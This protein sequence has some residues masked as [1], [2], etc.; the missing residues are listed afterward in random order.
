VH[1]HIPE[2]RIFTALYL[3]GYRNQELPANSPFGQVAGIRSTT[4]ERRMLNE[5][6]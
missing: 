2:Q 6:K 3:S 5:L 4:R 1:R